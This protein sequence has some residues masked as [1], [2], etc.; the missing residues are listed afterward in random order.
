VADFRSGK[1][2][3]KL[4]QTANHVIA[5]G[6]Q[7]LVWDA[8]VF[9]E[10]IGWDGTSQYIVDRDGLYLLHLQVGRSSVASSSSIIGRIQASSSTIQ[11]FQS[12]STTAGVVVA[13]T[14]VVELGAGEPVRAN[15]TFHATLS[16]STTFTQTQFW[17]A[18][19]RPKRWT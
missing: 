7:D 17:G 16:S 18:R 15:V 12:A 1:P 19:I 13:C 8:A 6:A 14:T 11:S 4:E 9:E 10:P 3:F 5:A 2:S